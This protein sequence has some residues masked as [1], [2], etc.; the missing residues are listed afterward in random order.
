MTELTELVRWMHLEPV[1]QSEVSKK[2]KKKYHILM[3]IYIYIYIYMESR[4]IVLINQF[5]G[6][7]QRCRHTERTCGHGEGEGGIN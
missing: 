6:S 7:Q 4:K 1:I 5:G 3:H 2:E